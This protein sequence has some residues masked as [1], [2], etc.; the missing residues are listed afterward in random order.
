MTESG[1]TVVFLA[2]LRLGKKMAL[3][4]DVL[5][6]ASVEATVASQRDI[7]IMIVYT[8]GFLTLHSHTKVFRQKM[9]AIKHLENLKTWTRK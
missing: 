7:I 9:Q 8:Q 6:T 4:I 3:I 1:F 2:V 5:Y